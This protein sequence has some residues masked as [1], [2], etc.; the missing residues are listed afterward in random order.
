M[1]TVASRTF[2]SSPH[3]DATDTW[4]AIVELLTQG[5]DSEAKRELRAVAGI[6]SSL[7][8]D[9]AP[10]SAPIIA[11]CEGP[12]TRIYCLYD[13]DAIDGAAASEDSL[14]FDPLSGDWKISLPCPKDELAWVQAALKRHTS[15]ISARDL[16]SG[17]ASDEAS[18]VKSHSLT[19]DVEGFLKS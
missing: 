5:K 6:A 14:G 15:R 12:R 17:I 2:R 3:R 10:E 16:S 18:T 11:I 9:H 7:I 1:T 4:N 19:L 8:A 13:D